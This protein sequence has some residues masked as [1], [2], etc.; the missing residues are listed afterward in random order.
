MNVPGRADL[1]HA[2]QLGAQMLDAAREGDWKAVAGLRPEY[3]ALLRQGAP[4][5]DVERGFLLQVQQQHQQLVELTAQAR[6]SIA[7]QLQ[8]QRKNHRALNAYL[9]PCDGD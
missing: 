4:A 1:E 7:R 9:L 8:Q 3:D 6:D 2:L 5:N